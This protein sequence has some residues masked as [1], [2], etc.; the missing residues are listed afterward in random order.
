FCTRTNAGVARR[1]VFDAQGRVRQI[2]GPDARPITLHYGGLDRVV[3]VERPDGTHVD[4]RYD[5]EGDLVRITNESGE[6]H[7]LLRNSA[8][9]ISREQTFDGRTVDYTYDANGELRSKS[10][11]PLQV[12]ALTAPTGELLHKEFADGT[13]HEFEYDVRG[14]LLRARN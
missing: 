11:G 5:R 12:S 2:I 9:Y 7:R 4:Y 13:S 8:G 1:T 14:R 3:R 6:Q 10:D